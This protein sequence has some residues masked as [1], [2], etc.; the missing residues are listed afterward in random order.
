MLKFLAMYKFFKSFIFL[1]PPE[2]AHNFIMALLKCRI[3]SFILGLFC[4]G[5]RYDRPKQIL[6]LN[7]PNFVGIA[8]G[9]DKDGEAIDALANLGFGFIEVGTVTPRPQPGNKKPRLFR[10]PEYKAIINRMG[11]NNAG[12]Q[13]LK[14]KIKQNK[15]KGYILGVNIGKNKTTPLE[16][17][18]QDYLLSFRE[19]YNYA[20]Y[21]VVNVSSPNT[22]NLR[23]LQEA[24]R[25]DEILAKLQGENERLGGNKP[26]FLKIAPDLTFEQIDRILEVVKK[27]KIPG[28]V[29]TNTTI[30]RDLIGTTSPKI[31][32]AG[33][34]SGLP[35]KE[36]SNEIIRYIRSKDKNLVIIGV[37]G[38]MTPQDALEK[39]QAGADLIQIYTGLIYNGPCFVKKIKKFLY[40]NGF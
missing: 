8:A 21:F 32:E 38:I 36:L 17:A 27:N 23:D 11:F 37:G 26:I 6:G 34:L 15:N 5:K 10:L 28:V 29:A 3:F 20:D 40:V 33:G 19:L 18:V 22:P 9:F 35:L 7:F 39:L 1:L 12:V 25:L 31:Q 16:D 14:Q 2:T 30:R 13:S 4:K 24:E